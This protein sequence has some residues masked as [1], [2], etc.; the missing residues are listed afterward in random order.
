MSWT[1]TATVA[2]TLGDDVLLF[3]SM[4]AREALS[5]PF[6][7]EVEMLSEKDNIKLE[8]LLGEPISIGLETRQGSYREFNGIVTDFALVGQLGKTYARYRASVRPWLWMLTQRKNSRIFQKKTVLEVIKKIFSEHG[9]TEI[10]ESLASDVYQKREFL[11]QYRETDFN[12]VSRIMEEE[13]IYY[14]FK[15]E[16]GKH[17]LNLCDSVTVHDPIKGYEEVPYYPKMEGERRERDHVD[18]WFTQRRV[19]SR[20]YAAYDFNFE[21]PKEPMHGEL[22]QNDKE[23]DAQYEVYEYPGGFMQNKDGTEVA[24]MR[25]EELQADYEIVRGTGNAR[26]LTPGAAFSL[27]GF[28]RDDQNKQYLLVDV[29]YQIH[30]SGY[31]SGKHEAE[32]PD[33]RVTFSA[34][35][36]N[37]VFRPPRVTRKPRVEGP[38]T[39]FVVGKDGEDIWTDE[40]GRVKLQF[41]WDRDKK[42]NEEASCFV[43]VAQIWAGSGFGGIHLPR[44]GQEVIVDFL[45]GDPDRPIVTGRVYNK[46][47]RVPYKLPDNQTQSGIKSRSTLKGT[48]DNFNE[49]RFEDKKGEEEFHIQAEKNMTTLVKNDQTTTVQNNRSAGITASDSV[50]VGGDRSLSVTGKRTV[51]VTKSNTETYSDTRTVTVTKTNDFTVTGAHTGTYKD[52]RTLTIKG[53][54]SVTVQSVGKTNTVT[55]DYVNTASVKYQAKQGENNELLLTGAQAMLKNQ[56]C[57]VTLNGGTLTIEASEKIEL[58]VGGN[59]I[60]IGSDGTIGVTA[61]T[62]VSL[63]G[64]KGGSVSLEAASASMNGPQ[65]T[66]QAQ[67]VTQVQGALVKIN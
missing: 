26:G 19:R 1:R 20:A 52:K 49:I 28:P 10:H 15:H 6:L 57:S 2:T 44:I 22:A 66:V 54:D 37:K 36:A 43:R 16:K 39:A 12:F 3:F 8:S 47:N 21:D 38:Q 30:V 55:G 46:L 67:G 56:N 31:E 18:T 24:K 7:Y 62:S 53:P 9:Y 51:S 59:T 48:E 27:S 5:S 4:A 41:H 23:A 35:P 65:C 29:G 17:T 50:T 42:R 45:E 25:L 11:V 60:T 58:K 63:S 40:Y 13:G 32:P 33:Y 64:G 34:I 14:F 61:N